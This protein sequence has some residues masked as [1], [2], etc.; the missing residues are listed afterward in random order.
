MPF[1]LQILAILLAALFFLFTVRM[2]Q[3]GNAEIRQMNKWLI[4]ALILMVGAIFPRLFT[5]IANFFGITTLTSLALYGLTAVLIVI[6]LTYQVLLIKE[7]HNNKI[8][9]QEL[10]LLKKEVSDLKKKSLEKNG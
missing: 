10:S 5:S 8:L 7:E 9:I 4:I 6:S 3:K 2:T 1:R